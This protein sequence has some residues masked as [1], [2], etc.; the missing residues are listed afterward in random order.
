MN[1]QHLQPS[2]FTVE[3]HALRIL[4]LSLLLLFS[5]LVGT[6][7][8]SWHAN[9]SSSR[10]A[11]RGAQEYQEQLVE[12]SLVLDEAYYIV[13]S[14]GPYASMDD[15]PLLPSVVASAV[16]DARSTTPEEARKASILQWACR[17]LGY[18]NH[19]QTCPNWEPP[20]IPALPLPWYPAVEDDPFLPWAE[21]VV[22]SPAI[23]HLRHFFEI[24]LVLGDNSLT[25]EH[26]S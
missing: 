4:F 6:W 18:N 11:G 22:L 16:P 14:S 24:M 20:M 26:Q 23:N 19:P 5:F 21:A 9:R 10:D 8:G 2:T 17:L 25:R 13:E 1:D 15:P 7:F 3:H 12:A